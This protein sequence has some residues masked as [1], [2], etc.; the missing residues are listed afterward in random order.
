MSL[1]QNHVKVDKCKVKQNSFLVTKTDS[2]YKG[3]LT[4]PELL[5]KSS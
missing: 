2:Y 5:G 1:R 4:R 3:Q